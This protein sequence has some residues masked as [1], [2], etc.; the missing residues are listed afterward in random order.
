L[1]EFALYM[2]ALGKRWVLSVLANDS[3]VEYEIEGP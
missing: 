3:V 1:S 2:V